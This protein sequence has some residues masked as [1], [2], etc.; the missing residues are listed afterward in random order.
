MFLPNG[1][2]ISSANNSIKFGMIIL[3]K[4]LIVTLAGY[5]IESKSYLISVYL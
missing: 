5:V 3:I 1:T 2:D 4:D